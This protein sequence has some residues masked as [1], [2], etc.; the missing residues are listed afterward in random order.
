VSSPVGEDRHPA[1]HNEHAPYRVAGRGE[2]A[3]E[4]DDHGEGGGHRACGD[5]V[6]HTRVGGRPHPHRHQGDDSRQDGDAH[7]CRRPRRL[8]EIQLV[9][10][11]RRRNQRAPHRGGEQALDGH[12]VGWIIGQD[13][14]VDD[15]FEERGPAAHSINRPWTCVRLTHRGTKVARDRCRS[16]SRT[17]RLLPRTDPWFLSLPLRTVRACSRR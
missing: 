14:D 16:T 10:G 2:D 11:K 17:L 6:H 4:D 7:R 3:A 15:P 12:Q 5:H 9:D 8:V 13:G 1:Q